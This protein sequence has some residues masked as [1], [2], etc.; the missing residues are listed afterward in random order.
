MDFPTL[1]SGPLGGWTS[2]RSTFSRL[3]EPSFPSVFPTDLAS[4]KSH[5]RVTHSDEDAYLTSLIPV[6][7]LMVEQYLS[8][9]LISRPVVQWMDV[10][11]GF[12]PA[13]VSFLS[14]SGRSMPWFS[15]FRAP[16]LSFQTLA[17]VNPAGTEYV[18]DPA[19]YFVDL[20]DKDAP[21]RVILN[22]GYVWP[23][24]VRSA[25]SVKASYTVGYGPDAA[26]VPPTLKHGVLLVAGALYSN[27]G[28]SADQPLEILSLPAV[29]AVLAPF[30]ILKVGTL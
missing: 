27:R 10:V 18:V 30:R 26:S 11:P 9:A 19:G 24:D 8:R 28:D 23:S 5:L 25:K 7:T 13:D 22:Q 12:G 6:A 3:E 17:F 21:A 15:L 29:R 14:R 20:S 4:V 2:P 1:S 16:A